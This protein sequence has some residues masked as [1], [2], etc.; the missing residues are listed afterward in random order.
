MEA[1]QKKDKQLGLQVATIFLKVKLK[2]DGG[3]MVV[4]KVL[5]DEN[6]G[7]LGIRFT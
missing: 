6:G 7:D 4:V 5:R 1:R 2:E 3:S